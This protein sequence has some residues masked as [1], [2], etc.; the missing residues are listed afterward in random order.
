MEATA[1]SNTAAGAGICKSST[2]TPTA[3]G[4]GESD[5][6][7]PASWSDSATSARTGIAACTSYRF[8][9]Q[10]PAWRQHL[11]EQGFCVIKTVADEQQLAA[12][13]R[14][15]WDDIEATKKGVRRDD[16]Q[17]WKQWH[18][19]QRGIVSGSLAQG[20]GAWYVRGLPRIKTAF[21]EIWGDDDLIVSMD[22]ALIWRPWYGRD[23]C[24]VL[25]QTEGLHLD[26]NPVSKPGLEC[27]QGM[28]PLFAV[29]PHT[30]GLAVVPGSHTGM[31][32]EWRR[33]FAGRG[34]WCVLPCDDRLQGQ[35][36]LVVAEAGDLVLWDAR[37]VHGGMVGPGTDK[38]AAD[39]TPELARLTQT[40]SM[41]PRAR[42]SE[43]CLRVRREGFAKG[44]TFNHS[45]HEAGSSS[46][47][48][49]CL[50]RRGYVPPDLTPAQ[51]ALI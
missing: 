49:F 30:G 37:T 23:D 48:V 34:D 45:P 9:I 10:D 28:V 44:V 40:V 21:A 32:S 8:N 13:R 51:V 31:P 25:P 50:Q 47:T 36:R 46:G 20:K 38:T 41:V 19:D 29:T 17:T 14:L 35:E 27:V 4:G 5:P 22:C 15:F 39:A 2:D 12:A 11:A 1:P 26:Q 43:K 24:G 42:A 18:I 16:A 6:K 7:S 33:Q 3:G